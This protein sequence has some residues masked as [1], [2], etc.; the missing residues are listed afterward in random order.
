MVAVDTNILVRLL[1]GDDVNQAHTAQSLFAHEIWIAKTVLLETAWVLRSLY[2]FEEKAI[3]DA[4]AKVLGLR[5]VQTEDAVGV[6]ASL[7]LV[8]H[9]IEFSDAMHLCSRPPG[10]R[11]LSFD[12]SFVR[13]AQRTGLADVEA[14]AAK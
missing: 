9:G 6:R 2:G 13:R 11:F 4:F 8:A 14:P 1:T 3:G 7:S 10:A 12:K 5:N